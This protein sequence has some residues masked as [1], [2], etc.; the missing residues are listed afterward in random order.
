MVSVLGLLLRSEA[1]RGWADAAGL[2]LPLLPSFMTISS[3]LSCFHRLAS[4]FF[5]VRLFCETRCGLG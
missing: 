3:Y 1:R 4:S 2:L 5:G